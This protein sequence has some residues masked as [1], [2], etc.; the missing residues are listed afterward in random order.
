MRSTSCFTVERGGDADP[1]DI[2]Q[3]QPGRELGEAPAIDDQPRDREPE[4]RDLDQRP[5]GPLHAEEQ[6]APQH[7]EKAV[8]R[9]QPDDIGARLD[10]G[11]G[12][13]GGERGHRGER[14]DQRPGDAIEPA[15][16]RPVGLGETLVPGAEIGDRRAARGDDQ[17]RH[18]RQDDRQQAFT[19]HSSLPAAASRPLRPRR[20][21]RPET[22]R[23]D[24][25][26]PSR[27][28]SRAPPVCGAPA[29]C[30]CNSAR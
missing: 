30:A 28:S 9:E 18:R 3:Q 14:K 8:E 16:R 10:A 22:G 23:A 21:F 20:R 25:P 6:Q 2:G 4:Q 11:R 5:V 27:R 7:V 12:A 13:P 19:M 29:P 17:S 24:A 1:G 26:C 15:G